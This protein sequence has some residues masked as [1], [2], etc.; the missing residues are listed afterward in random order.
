MSKTIIDSNKVAVEAGIQ[1]VFAYLTD[2]NNIK[3]LLPQDKISDWESDKDFCSFKVQNAA[4]IPLK[5]E[6]VNEFDKIDI[7][8]GDKAPFPFTLQIH[9]SEKDGGTEGYIHF[10]GDINMFLKMMVEKPLENLFNYMA[11]KLQ[12]KFAN[13]QK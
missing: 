13:A 7:V 12:E 3:E 10:E 9:L 11:H 6:A 1:E 2:F 5:K 4:T 8:S